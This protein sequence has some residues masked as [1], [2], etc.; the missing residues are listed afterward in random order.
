MNKEIPRYPRKQ[1]E[2]KITLCVSA[3]LKSRWDSLIRDHA[4]QLPQIVREFLDDTTLKIG[5]QLKAEA[6]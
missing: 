5:E 4:V 3:E 1:L 2:A 6:V